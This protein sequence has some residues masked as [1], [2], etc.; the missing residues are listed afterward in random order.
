MTGSEGPLGIPAGLALATA[1]PRLLTRARSLTGRGHQ[2]DFVALHAAALEDRSHAPIGAALATVLERQLFRI[3]Q[4]EGLMER[5]KRHAAMRTVVE[6]WAAARQDVQV[7]AAG[8]QRAH[9][10]TALTLIGLQA[11]AGY[12]ALM[13]AI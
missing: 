9:A 5:L 10:A 4:E 3:L 12:F 13:R 6:E 8:P 2:L 1:S 7:L 11:D